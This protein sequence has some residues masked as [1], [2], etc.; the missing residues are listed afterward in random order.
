MID[1]EDVFLEGVNVKAKGKITVGKKKP[2]A[3]KSA[4]PH[5]KPA[6]RVS[7]S[8]KVTKT[9]LGRMAA[10]LHA[11]QAAA[12]VTAKPAAKR[13]PGGLAKAFGKVQGKIHQAT[14]AAQSAR[15]R[16]G[17]SAVVSVK[18]PKKT[19]AAAL[20][21]TFK[22]SPVRP[23]TLTSKA[24][25]SVAAKIGLAGALKL[26]AK[27][28]PI[29]PQSPAITAAKAKAAIEPIA[30]ACQC[31]PAPVIKKI[32]VHLAK[33]GYPTGSAKNLLARIFDMK[34]SLE[35]AAIQR[36]ATHEHKTLAAK[37]SFE[38]QVLKRLSELSQCLS[39]CHPTRT[40][41]N[42]EILKRV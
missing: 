33:R 24:R 10:K 34:T 40:R 9:P 37:Q 17:A 11:V 13:K 42:L 18:L 4:K 15:S 16:A 5:K 26:A 30:T 1:F 6:A 23:A 20:R 38:T 29:K 32:D 22:S 14:H 3:K 2:A 12:H 21:A 19:P 7:M 39:A 35:K 31:H 28:P 36:L 41:A 27:A 8:A 25:T